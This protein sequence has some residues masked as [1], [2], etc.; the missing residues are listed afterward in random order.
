MH[1]SQQFLG[2]LG[3]LRPELGI[4]ALYGAR[5]FEHAPIRQACDM[6]L[7]WR[8]RVGCT[9]DALA[10]EGPAG[11]SR[12]WVGN[13][14]LVVAETLVVALKL[15]REALRAARRRGPLRI[16]YRWTTLTR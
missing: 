5:T 15:L 12:G 16:A 7:P 1:I 9:M 6:S 14:I 13:V 10:T 4:S 8:L 11:R 2:I 3:Y